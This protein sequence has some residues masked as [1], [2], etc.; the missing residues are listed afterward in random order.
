MILYKYFR[1]Y[2]KNEAS[3]II[4]EDLL[5]RLLIRFT[6][7]LEFDDPFDSIEP[8]LEIIKS[9]LALSNIRIMKARLSRSRFAVDISD[10]VT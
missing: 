5:A 4:V 1:P 9:N 6:Q 3:C 10:F 7:P 8:T 2:Q